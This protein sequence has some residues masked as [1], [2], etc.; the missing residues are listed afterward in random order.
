MVVD[1]TP[2]KRSTDAPA[3]AQPPPDGDA[4]LPHDDAGPVIIT[5]LW[6]L[7]SISAIS[8]AL[9]VYC[10]RKTHRGLWWDDY[11]LLGSWV[12]SLSNTQYQANELVR[13]ALSSTPSAT[14]T[15]WST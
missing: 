7:V 4:T 12:G 6:V 1:T 9:R 10:K 13:P 5:V 14:H 2:D 3:S 8:L 15:P 11:I